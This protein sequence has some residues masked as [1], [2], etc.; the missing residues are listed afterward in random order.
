VARDPARS[1][2]LARIGTALAILLLVLIVSFPLLSGVVAP[3][4]PNSVQNQI[5]E[6]MVASTGKNAAYCND[7]EGIAALETLV[8]K[9]ATAAD[10]DRAYKVYVNDADVLNAFAAPGG[11]VVIFKPIIDN[12]ESPNEVAG[13]LAHEMGHV[14]EDHPAKG[15]VEALGYG[16]FGLLTFGVTDDAPQIARSLLTNHYS[17]ADELDADQVGVDM[18]NTAGID[19]RGLISFFDKLKKAG[20][21]MPGA[22]EF[23]STHP[24]GD[25]RA[26]K[27]DGDIREGEP[28]LTD[29]QWKALRGICK[30]TGDAAPV[31]VEK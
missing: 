27:L 26:D 9:L 24:S 3:L 12:A 8:D 10:D 17:R 6:E 7:P 16:V 5:G 23:L 2:R 25:T 14:V 21:D 31:V 4:V 18:L 20:A 13:V 28:A 29:A 1:K 15:V 11:H 22:L 19:S 30:S